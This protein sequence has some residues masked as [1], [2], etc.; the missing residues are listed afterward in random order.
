MAMAEF[1]REIFGLD[2][3]TWLTVL[4]TIVFVAAAHAGLRWWSRHRASKEELRL[5]EAEGG[6]PTARYWIARGVRVAVPPLA[7]LMWIHGLYFPLSTLLSGFAP[8]AISAQA[9]NVLLFLR[10][11]G[12]IL[13]LVWLL[14]RISRTVDAWLLSFASRSRNAWDNA[15]A[16]FAGRT[17]RF[18]LPLVAIILGVPAL[19]VPAGLESVLQKGVSLILIGTIA[20]ILI[21]FM[22]AL[23]TLLV[24]RNQIDVPDNRRARGI[25]T[26]VMVIRK[27][28]VVMIAGFALA[29]M[30]MVFDSVRHFGT[31][32]IASAGVAG[33]IVGFAAQKSIATLLA[34]FQIALTQPIRI[35]DVVIVENEWGRIEEV[36]LTYVVVRIWDL[37]RLIVPITYFIERPFQ[38]WT[39]QSADL[40]GTVYLQVDYS[41]PLDELRDELKSVLEASTSW[42]RKACALQVTDARDRTLEVRVLA[43]A[44]DASAA[45][46]LRCEV[47]EKLVT[48]LQREYPESLPRIRAS[49]VDGSRNG[50][51]PR[52]RAPATR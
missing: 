6:N 20:F 32:I 17:V 39:R 8:A 25:Y 18:A 21:Q 7:L 24:K 23:A 45:W 42:D 40:L 22:N 30:L 37:R 35:D 1:D 11:L 44:A 27:I 38:N 10:G 46:D 47:R 33:I 15:M 50:A 41:V 49:V 52:V 9:A 5:T 26:Q 43:S 4:V 3:S 36:T 28:V 13:A 31:A 16:P 2:A 48:W 14:V 51:S 29:S 19:S 12:T 34:G